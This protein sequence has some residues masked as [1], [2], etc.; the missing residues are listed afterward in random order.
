VWFP[1]VGN[2]VRYVELIRWDLYR[3]A[4]SP[5]LLRKR[6]LDVWHTRIY[7]QYS[8]PLNRGLCDRPIPRPEESYRLWCVSE[9][10]QVKTK[11]PRHLLW[12]G[13]RGNDCETKHLT[14]KPIPVA[15]RSHA[16]VCG[17]ALAGIVGSNPT[18]GMD[19]RLLYSVCV[20]R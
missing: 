17:R 13:G 3:G 9:C 2:P 6:H 4:D 19:V 11:Q 20:V 18:G 15:A 7:V 5:L 16:Y 12:A 14:I 8:L 1:H 10:D